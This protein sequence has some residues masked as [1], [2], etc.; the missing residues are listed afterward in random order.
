[1]IMIIMNFL[2]T[3]NL[4]FHFQR[5]LSSVFDWSLAGIGWSVCRKLGIAGILQLHDIHRSDTPRDIDD[6]DLSIVSIY[7]S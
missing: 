7:V 6:T 2:R 3:I 5:T 1:M 4:S